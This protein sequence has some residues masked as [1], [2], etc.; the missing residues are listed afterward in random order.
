MFENL[1]EKLQ[2]AFKNL[3]G[4]GQVTEENMT[5]ALREI[6][7]ALIEADVSLNVVTEVI[8]HIRVRAMGQEVTTSLSPTEQI[9]KIV[10]DELINILGKDTARFKF[11]VAAAEGDPDGGAAGFA[12]R[13]PPRP[14]WRG[15]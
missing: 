11:V 10:H 6:R 5:E 7:V 12:A 8:E 3:R 1:S 2:R 15:G 14:S 4:Q 9:V 13:R